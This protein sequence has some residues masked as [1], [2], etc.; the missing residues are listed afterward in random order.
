MQVQPK[1]SRPEHHKIL[2]EKPL[3]E[4]RRRGVA[5]KLKWNRKLTDD[6][7]CR[8][9]NTN[10]FF[11]DKE[12]FTPEEENIFARMCVECPVMLICLEWG[13]AHEKRGVWGGTT[14]YRRHQE[15]KRRGWVV[16]EPFSGMVK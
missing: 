15:R 6:A 5:F 7:N 8:G 16:T 2:G 14:P 3:N 4:G 9:I 10:L 13:L 11:P 1:Q 12:L